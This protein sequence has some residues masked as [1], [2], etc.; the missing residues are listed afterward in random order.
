VYSCISKTSRPSTRNPQKKRY[1]RRAVKIVAAESYN[2][3]EVDILHLL[4]DCRQIVTLQ[5]VF[6]GFDRVYLVMEE[7]RGD[8]LT[9]L[10]TRVYYREPQ[11]KK[12]GYTLLQALEFI[13]MRGVAHR[14]IKPENILVAR[15]KQG[16]NEDGSKIKLADF[17]L[18]RRFRDDLGNRLEHSNMF[19]LCGSPWYAAPEVFGRYPDHVDDVSYDERCDIWSGGIILY[20]CIA[21]YMPF[22]GAATDVEVVKQVC[23]GKFKFHD[24][25]WGKIS[26]DCKDLISSLLKVHPVQRCTLRE[27]LSSP[28]FHPST[29]M[30]TATA[31]E[32][33]TAA[34]ISGTEA[35]TLPAMEIEA[36]AEEVVSGQLP[37][38]P[39][40]EDLPAEHV[41][42]SMDDASVTSSSK[43]RSSQVMLL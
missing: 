42:S 16:D 23:R 9:E 39:P 29:S 36:I 25:Y 5:D 21:G 30:V 43:G 18:A 37:P 40:P 26:Q 6:F 4:R 10:N 8:L 19:T 7:M 32:T 28:W 15:S 11:A 35:P 1:A 22:M 31:T 13:H 2:R 34:P 14:D 38:L 41:I 24:Q 3:Q 27:A 20:L 12:L 33:P 17:G